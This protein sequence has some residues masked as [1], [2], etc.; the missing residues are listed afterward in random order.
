MVWGRQLFQL[1]LVIGM[2]IVI[3]AVGY[4]MDAALQVAEHR[5]LRRY[6]GRA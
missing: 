5:L 2:M 1:D 6:G 4:A 3:G